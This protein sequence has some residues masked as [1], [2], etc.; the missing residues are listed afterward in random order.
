[1]KTF[2]IIHIILFFVLMLVYQC[3]SAQDYVVNVKGDTLTGSIKPLTFGPDKKVQVTSAD[4]KKTVVP[5]FQVKAYSLKGEVYQPVK[6]PSGYTFMKLLK[7]G[8]VSLYAFQ[9][10]NQTSYDGR[11]L[12]KRDGTGTEVPNLSFKKITSRFFNDCPAIESKIED[13]TYGKKDLDTII[14]EYNACINGRTAEHTQVIATRTEQ[15][16]KINSW[17]ILENKVKGLTEFEGKTNAL[18]MIGEI[19]NKISKSEK[20]PNFLINGLKG[21][22]TQPELQADLETALKELN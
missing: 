2:G 21:T 15:V 17:D 20:V 3:V 18:E 13:G 11:F 8:Y 19:K 9:L 7:A 22:L 10:E 14:D 1:M 4:K 5:I 12:L 6:G 16:K